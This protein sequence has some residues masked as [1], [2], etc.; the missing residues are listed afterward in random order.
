MLTSFI[1]FVSAGA[2]P[3]CSQPLGSPTCTPSSPGIPGQQVNEAKGAEGMAEV[4]KAY[5]YT[6]DR[7][8]GNVGAGPL[9]QEYLHFLQAPR[10][11]TPAFQALLGAPAAGS[12]QDD[13][14]RVTVLR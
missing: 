10:P 4:R 12:G 3:A 6:L 7:L 11:G 2:Q 9:W 1:C 14:H 13:S 5:E 8:G